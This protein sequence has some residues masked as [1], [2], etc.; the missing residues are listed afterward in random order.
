MPL[1]QAPA[2]VPLSAFCQETFPEMYVKK[3]EGA[4]A[5]DWLNGV[6][7]GVVA[8]TSYKGGPLPKNARVL[9]VDV[10]TGDG[11]QGRHSS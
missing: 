7:E 9:I 10:N 1:T 4:Y 6:V 3:Q 8:S 2:V 11:V 5:K